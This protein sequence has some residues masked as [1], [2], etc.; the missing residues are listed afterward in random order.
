MCAGQESQRGIAPSRSD[1]RHLGCINPLP[2]SP[3]LGGGEVCGLTQIQ[4]GRD[5][6]GSR[7][8][9]PD[10]PLSPPPL[11]GGGR[12]GGLQP[13]RC[14][15]RKLDDP[16]PTETGPRRIDDAH[17]QPGRNPDSAFTESGRAAQEPRQR[18]YR[19]PRR[20]PRQDPDG[21]TMRAANPD[22][23]PTA[24]LPIAA[25]QPR[26]DRDESPPHTKAGAPPV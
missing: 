20:Q 17:R 3:D 9:D 6:Y 13:W 16:A 11:Q 24:P 25:R 15:P 4:P 12:E 1:R 21:S 14:Q 26:Q 10:A 2:A 8:T 5:L 18:L 7:S 23:T 22:G 19:S